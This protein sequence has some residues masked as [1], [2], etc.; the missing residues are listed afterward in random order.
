MFFHS[1][2][3]W[4]GMLVCIGI[5]VFL[6]SMVY[7]VD[8]PKEP[9]KIYKYVKPVMRS[10]AAQPQ[11]KSPDQKHHIIN[12]N[13]NNNVNETPEDA[14]LA[15]KQPLDI[16]NPSDGK[17]GFPNPNTD[18]QNVSE[19]KSERIFGLTIEEIKERIP[20]LEREIRTNLTKAVKLYADLRS[21]DG[22]AGNSPEIATWR[23]E[24]WDEVKRL[25][26]DVAY[27]GKIT[28]YASYL[29]VVGGE[30]DPILPGGWIFEMTKPLPMRVNYVGDPQVSRH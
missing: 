18:I 2:W 30:T 6:G 12:V 21:T 15:T 20:V 4:S 26:H 10:D 5:L 16:E 9:I 27:T 24:T 1:K 17:S 13:K 23:Q 8:Q 29:K 3:F 19:V 25:F 11:D 28:Q 22:T 14:H 7:R